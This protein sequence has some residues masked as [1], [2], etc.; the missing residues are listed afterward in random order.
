MNTPINVS[1][2]R[3]ELEGTYEAFIQNVEIVLNRLNPDWSTELLKD[4]EAVK[5]HLAE[6]AGA[7]GLMIFGH[8]EHGKLLNIK[9]KPRKAIQYLIGNPLTA[10][11]MTQYDIRAA[12]YAP[13]R[14]IVYE[15]DDQ[16]LYAE[17]DL[18]SSLFGQFGVEEIL[19][20]AKGLDKSILDVILLSD[21][22]SK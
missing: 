5:Q 15:G 18:P 8:Q 20:V 4:P 6:V 19:E 11:E 9:G 14:I 16:V 22:K 3:V 13:L 17:Y 1:H 10:A 21:Q 12:L 7:T 2:Q